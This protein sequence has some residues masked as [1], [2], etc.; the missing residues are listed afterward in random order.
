M[1]KIFFSNNIKYLRDRQ[2]I[3]QENCAQ[4]LSMG[5]SKLSALENGQIKGLQPEDLLRFSDYFKVS[6]D[7]LLRVNLQQL[8]ELNLRQLI[9]G[10]DVYIKGGNLRVLAITVN[11]DN[12]ENVE[13][14]PIKAKAGYRAGYNDPQY[15][16]QLPKFHLPNLPK[17]KTYRIFP[18]SGDSMLPIPENSLVIGSFVTDLGRIKTGT[19]CIVVLKGTGEDF[20]F[21]SVENNLQN[22]RTFILHSLNDT[23]KPYTVPI[24]DVLEVWEMTSYMSDTVPGGNITM[25]F[26]ANALKDIQVKVGQI[27]IKK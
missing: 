6:I 8:G 9:A 26:I 14:V 11:Q 25:N 27:A 23:Y 24:E 4:N 12:E 7:T 3:S 2:R 13:L 16:G 18:T 5:R 21:K 20:V 22:D 1:E 17:G 15:I 10:N 19:L